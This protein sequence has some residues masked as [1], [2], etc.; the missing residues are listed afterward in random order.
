MKRIAIIPARGG[1]KRLPR[2]NVADFLGKPIIAYTIEAALACHL[3]DK[4]AVS[5]ED[6]EI[7]DVARR[8][9]ASVILRPDALAT[10]Q[11]Q[12]KDVCL[13]VLEQEAHAGRD[14]DG[15]GCLYATAP[16]RNVADISGTAGLIEPGVCEFSMAVTESR[17]ANT[18]SS[19]TPNRSRS[20]NGR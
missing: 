8:F 1:S 7:A 10:D 11:S 2:K 18:C 6:R 5:T 14:Y 19:E 4:V 15:F 12:V 9:G 3:F 17:P 16:L 20:S 13:H